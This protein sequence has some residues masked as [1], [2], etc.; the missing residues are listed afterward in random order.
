[1][2]VINYQLFTRLTLNHKIQVQFR[3]NSTQ[4]NSEQEFLSF[5]LDVSIKSV[6][7]DYVAVVSF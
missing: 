2:K 4:K 1:M 7:A 6:S 5:L 3:A